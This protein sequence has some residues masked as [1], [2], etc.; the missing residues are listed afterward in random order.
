MMSKGYLLVQTGGGYVVN[1]GEC[2]AVARKN[3]T[4]RRHWGH[5]EVGWRIEA[6]GKSCL[7]VESKD[8]Q[9]ISKGI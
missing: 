1:D 7:A 9:F 3:A 8:C 2:G 6:S 5:D 4:I